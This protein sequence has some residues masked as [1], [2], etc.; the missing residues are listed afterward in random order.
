MVYGET[1][2]MPLSTDIITRSL[3][4]YLK[5]KHSSPDTLHNTLLNIISKQYDN[6][7]HTSRYL[8]YIHTTLNSLGLSFLYQDNA[9]TT[10]MT[11]NQMK[12]IVKAQTRDQY[13]QNWRSGMNT[14]N[15]FIFYRSI[16]TD[17]QQ[18]SYLDILPS[19]YRKQLTKLRVGNHRLPIETGRWNN[20]PRNERICP[21]CPNQTLGDE[22]HYLFECN[23]FKSAREKYLDKFYYRY[24]SM[25]KAQSLF[26]SKNRN[27]LLQL[28]KLVEL[29]LK[30]E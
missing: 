19:K 11:F 1:G 29:I 12:I 8:H 20:T 4:F 23:T 25:Y 24:P 7:P 15:K 28:S 17:F 9:R 5:T 22:F 3:S 6:T 13:I 14:S 30:H 18:E 27:T 16:K 21:Q 10:R 26:C 2:C